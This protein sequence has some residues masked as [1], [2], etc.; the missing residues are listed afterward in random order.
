MRWADF[1]LLFNL[2]HPKS[3]TRLEISIEGKPIDLIPTKA[4]DLEHEELFYLEIPDWARAKD[5]I[6][7]ECTFNGRLPD[8]QR[9]MISLIRSWHPKFQSGKITFDDYEV[10]VV[11]PEGQVLISTGFETEHEFNNGRARYELRAQKV[12]DFGIITS[13]RLTVIE[14]VAGDVSVR[15]YSLPDTGR[16]GRPLLDYACDAINF[17]RDEFGFYP[18]DKLSVMPGEK[19]PTGGWPVT[20]NVV[21]IHNLDKLGDEAESYARWIVAHEISHQ[22]WGGYV[23]CSE[24]PDWLDIGLGIYMDQHYSEAR[25]LERYSYGSYIRGLREGADTTVI[26]PPERLQAAEFDYNSV[27]V[28]GKGYAIIS[29]LEQVLGE[30]LFRRIF[31]EA[32]RRFKHRDIG[33]RD[34]QILCEELSGE[35]LDW[36]FYQW[37]HTNRYLSYRVSSR[38]ESKQGEAYC[39]KVWVERMGDAHMPIPVQATFRDGKEIVLWTNRALRMTELTF[40][41]P[42]PCVK[43]ELDSE[44]HFPLIYPPLDPGE[45]AV[46]REISKLPWVRSGDMAKQL[47]ERACNIGLKSEGLWYK[48][49]LALYDGRF[50]DEALK[51][52]RVAQELSGDFMYTFLSMLWQG[53]ILDLLG[54]RDAALELYRKVHQRLIETGFE[55]EARH[56]LYGLIFNRRWVEERLKQPFMRPESSTESG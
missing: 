46:A 27:I 32:L 37:L 41:S 23:V 5:V 54:R 51:A 43:L 19:G 20:S 26:Q 10:T 42:S 14:G 50:Y 52:L 12:K 47:Y 36:F 7:L 3:R 1:D 39:L 56:D 24:F 35:D 16:W 49:D 2:P 31:D 45:T 48:L 53:H 38:E 29:M 22:Y 4:A 17:Y 21:G 18:Q 34:F 25:S 33:V 13:D 44:G 9:D 28:H 40:M 30:G 11:M 15:S 55:G 8:P 6:T